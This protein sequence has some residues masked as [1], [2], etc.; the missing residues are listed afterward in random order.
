MHDP[1]P[2]SRPRPPPLPPDGAVTGLDEAMIEALVRRFY[3]SAREDA[4]L[5]PVFARVTDWE[6]HI[7]R[8]CAFWS[9]VALRTGRYSG[10]P[11]RAHLPLG[12]EPAHFA[13]W[14]ALFGDTAR[15]ICPPA[16]AALLI[17]RARRIGE[18][19][20]LGI[21]AHLGIL[22]PDRKSVV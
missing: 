4:L 12:L 11:M 5:G 3:G 22:P 15:E 19:L 1:V 17:A 9:S 8:I 2:P 14:M 16:A 18:S 6:H 13:R 7:A 21:T 10:Q 20:M